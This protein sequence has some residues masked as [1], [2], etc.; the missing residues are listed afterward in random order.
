LTDFKKDAADDC[1]HTQ[2]HEADQHKI[3]LTKDSEYKRLFDQHTNAMKQQ[4]ELI[5]QWVK[6]EEKRLPPKPPKSPYETNE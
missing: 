6:E 5:E 4:S 2:L 3:D 1:V